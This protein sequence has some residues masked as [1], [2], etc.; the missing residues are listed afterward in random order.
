MSTDAVIFVLLASLFVCLILN[1]PLAF[2]ILIST[3]V[4]LLMDG[5]I[6]ISFLTQTLF[7]SN[8][9]FPLLAI[10]FFIL[11]GDLMS[12]GGIAT[13]L[14]NFFQGVFRRVPGSLGI[15]TICASLIF[16]AISG[17]GAATVAA[18]GGIMIP[19][20]IRQGYSKGYA[21]SLAASAGAL[22]PIIPPS[23]VFILYGV[24]AGES[25]GDLF[26]AGIIPGMLIAIALII[27]N[28]FV[29][30]KQ[31][32]NQNA[33]ILEQDFTFLKGLNH[34]KWSLLAPIIILGGIYGGIVTPTE[35][36]VLAVVY[37]LVIGIFVH[38]EL[39]L[40]E[41]P[42][43]FMKSSLTAGTVL[44]FISSASFFGRVLSLKQIPQAIADFMASITTDVF[45]TLFILNIFLLI[46]GMFIETIAAVVI[47]V[48]LLLPIITNVGIDPLHF[49]VIMCV[50]LSIGLV[51]PPF[52]INLFIASKT[53]GIPFEKTFKDIGLL[54]GVLVLVL[55]I[56]SFVP[57]LSLFLP[58]LG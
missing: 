49:G 33:N 18:I 50:N 34:A 40:K 17:S 1:I 3:L 37:S 47:F 20:M 23:I 11:A 51:T 26:I 44:I 2:T 46:V 9:S 27:V 54:I 13:R 31:K 22:G 53:A 25:I 12:Q 6:P 56:I 52:G 5:S 48:P 35:A 39:K 57:Q 10:P 55:L 24:M 32:I 42:A 14:V 15:I 30:K 36:A 58:S 7:G 4:V 43:L 38:K 41:L 29:F 16:A 45:L 21:A 19:Y 28:F 8:D